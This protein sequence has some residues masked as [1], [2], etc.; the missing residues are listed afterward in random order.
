ML[1]LFVWLFFCS[2]QSPSLHQPMSLLA[3]STEFSDLNRL[4]WGTCLGTC[5]YL[6]NSPYQHLKKSVLPWFCA[7]DHALK[8]FWDWE[9]DALTYR[10]DAA[11]E[12]WFPRPGSDTE[13][14]TSVHEVI[15]AKGWCTSLLVGSL[16][17]SDLSHG[18]ANQPKEGSG[19]RA[20][21]A[22]HPFARPVRP[23]IPRET[24]SKR[25]TV[26]WPGIRRRDSSAPGRKEWHSKAIKSF[27]HFGDVT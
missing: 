25:R 20:F 21:Q 4:A 5:W 9:V 1:N 13:V 18:V 26:A 12:A 14:L 8:T 7:N 16:A 19:W 15:L 23:R 27:A 11:R 24:C 2:C 22:F 10:E 3:S 17:H 6:D